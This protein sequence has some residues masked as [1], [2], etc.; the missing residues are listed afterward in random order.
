MVI[1]TNSYDHVILDPSIRRRRKISIRQ[2]KEKNSTWTCDK[3]GAEM[4]DS[5]I[6][7]IVCEEED[8][9]E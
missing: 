6:N 2:L 5:Y 7:C 3:C 4:L 1:G 8:D 9:D